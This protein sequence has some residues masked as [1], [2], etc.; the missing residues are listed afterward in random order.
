[1]P[2]YLGSRKLAVQ[3]GE[4]RQVQFYWQES[5]EEYHSTCLSIGLFFIQNP[6]QLDWVDVVGKKAALFPGFSAVYSSFAYLSMSYRTQTVILVLLPFRLYPIPFLPSAPRYPPIKS[7]FADISEAL[8][9]ASSTFKF[10]DN[11]YDYVSAPKSKFTYGDVMFGEFDQGAKKLQGC[12]ADCTSK[13]RLQARY[14]SRKSYSV[15]SI[16]SAVIVT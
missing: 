14:Y 7:K 12:T 15:C 5:E 16:E 3:L 2:K 6:E 9:P 1:M 10:S 4:K 11:Y 8:L 13:Y